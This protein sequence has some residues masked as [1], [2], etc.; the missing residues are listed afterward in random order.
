MILGIGRCGGIVFGI[1]CSGA[2]T[3]RVGVSA[4]L[5]NSDS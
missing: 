3:G 2:E 4:R 1:G 5:A